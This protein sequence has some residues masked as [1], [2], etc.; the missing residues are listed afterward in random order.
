MKKLLMIIATSVAGFATIASCSS[1]GASEKLGLESAKTEKVYVYGNCEM[2]KERIES[3]SN[4]LSDVQS[5]V[6]DVESKILTVSFDSTKTSVEEVE[7]EIASAGHDT[8][9][10]KASE[11][12]YSKLPGCCQY[13][14]P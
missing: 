10:V 2:C 6:W 5:A 13:T 11:E 7:K 9:N 1:E 14:R 4:G 3:A 8:K 12:V